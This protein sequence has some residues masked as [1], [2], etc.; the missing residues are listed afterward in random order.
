[1]IRW[2]ISTKLLNMTFGS[3]IYFIFFSL[4]YFLMQYIL[5]I[6]AMAYSICSLTSL[7]RGL[8]WIFLTDYTYLFS[9]CVFFLSFL[10][11]YVKGVF[12]HCTYQS[13]FPLPPLLLLLTCKSHPRIYR[14]KRIKYLNVIQKCGDI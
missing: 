11:I 13:Q 10:F 2:N 12:F 6:V 9:E 4:K 1:M 8:F 3:I 5:I 14:N 7:R